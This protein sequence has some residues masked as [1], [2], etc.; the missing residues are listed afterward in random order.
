MMIYEAVL[1]WCGKNLQSLELSHKIEHLA[2]KV[3][4]LIA[5]YCRN[6]CCINLSGV[7]LTQY[8]LKFSGNIFKG[9]W[10]LNLDHSFP[11]EAL[12]TWFQNNTCLLNGII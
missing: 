7:P 12:E 9:M 1:K 10:I 2:A 6:R 8:G 3:H 4:Q 5:K 11:S